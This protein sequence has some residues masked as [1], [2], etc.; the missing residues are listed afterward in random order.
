VA[1]A[2]SSWE[3]PVHVDTQIETQNQDENGNWYWFNSATG[4]SHWM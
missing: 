1:T 3:M 4:E 2:Q